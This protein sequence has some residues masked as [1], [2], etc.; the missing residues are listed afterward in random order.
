[1]LKLMFGTTSQII[2]PLNPYFCWLEPDHLSIKPLL[3]PS[4]IHPDQTKP[5]Q[6]GRIQDRQAQ[7]K[8]REAT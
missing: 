1:M 3:N 8:L 2:Y 7:L 5:L 6:I 4:I